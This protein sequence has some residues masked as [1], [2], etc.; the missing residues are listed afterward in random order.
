MALMSATAW[1]P[2]GQVAPAIPEYD[3]DPVAGGGGGG[4]GSFTLTSGSDS[5]IKF[6]VNGT[7]SDTVTVHPG[8]VVEINVYYK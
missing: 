4:G 1:V 8:D 3:Y 2:S 5:N 6:T 7:T